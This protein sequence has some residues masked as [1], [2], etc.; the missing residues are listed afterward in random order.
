M[1]EGYDNYQLELFNEPKV[2]FPKRPLGNRFFNFLHRHEKK[3]LI[4]IGIAV[5]C[6]ISFSLGVKRGKKLSVLKS[7]VSFDL[8]EKKIEIKK[9]PELN[10]QQE[11]P[12]ITNDDAQGYT[13]QLASYKAK[14]FADREAEA[15]KKKGLMPLVLY[16]GDY[17]VLCA[18][19]FSDKEEARSSMSKLKKEYKDCY[20]R[21]L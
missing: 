16:K 18:G 6:M 15:L 20:L 7:S 14:K 5:S 10:Q 17:V 9:S 21:R 1:I 4:V 12:V 11:Q 8:A 2:S 3:F 13:V 19:K